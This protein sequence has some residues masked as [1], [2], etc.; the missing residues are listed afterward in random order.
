MN[1]VVIDFFEHI[2]EYRLYVSTDGETYTEVAHYTDGE[3]RIRQTDT[4]TFPTVTARYVRYE[5]IKRFHIPEWNAYYSGGIC[6]LRIRRGGVCAVARGDGGLYGCRG[7]DCTG[8]PE[9][10]SAGGVDF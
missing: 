7:A 6:G 3:E 2:S 1:R 8:G 9:S 4:L 10:V 5:Q